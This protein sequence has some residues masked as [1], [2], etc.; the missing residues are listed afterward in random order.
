M[1]ALARLALAPDKMLPMHTRPLLEFIT[2][3]GA[4]PGALPHVSFAELPTPVDTH[5]DAAQELGLGALLVKRD[6][7]TGKAYGGNKVRKLEFLLGDAQARGAKSVLTFGAAG[8]NHCLATATYARTLGL[9][10]VAM[11]V[12]QHNAH[13]VRSNLLA[14]F[15]RGSQ[16]DLRGNRLAVALGTAAHFR[17]EYAATGTWPSVFPAGGSSPVGCLGYVN[18]ALE[19]ADQVAAGAC[20]EPDVLYVASGTM[21][22]CVGLLLGLALSPLRTRVCAVAV[23]SAP[24]TSDKKTPKLFEATNRVLHDLYPKIPHLPFPAERFSLRTEFLG[25]EYALYTPEGMAA[26]ADARAHL[27]LKLEGTYTGKTYAALLADAR[28]GK[29]AGQNVLFWD[30]YSSADLSPEIAQ[31]DYHALPEPLHRFFEDPVQPLDTQ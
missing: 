15:A 12:P 29:L 2:R 10:C 17:E 24:Y 16:L 23:T 27:H 7:L 21:G 3:Q 11:L 18:A 8:S 13:S 22:T 31:L 30:T 14:G 20:P 25:Q 5:P 4:A 26:V 9:R 6:D 1:Q 28:S 19:L